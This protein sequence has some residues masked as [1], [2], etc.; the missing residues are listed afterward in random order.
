MEESREA[1]GLREVKKAEA[2]QEQREK[3]KKN[4]KAGKTEQTGRGN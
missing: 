3:K 4:M 1:K 2:E